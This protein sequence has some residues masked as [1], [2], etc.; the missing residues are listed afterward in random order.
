ME[1]SAEAAAAAKLKALSDAEALE[2]KQEAEKMATEKKWKLA[3]EA[4]AA[5]KVATEKA[6]EELR[7]RHKAAS[8]AAAEAAAL[9]KKAAIA[10]AKA[11][12][13]ADPKLL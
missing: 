9:A 13:Y 6:K 5:A 3:T 12:K 2:K 8:D 4:N 1:K 11:Q 7:A 10:K